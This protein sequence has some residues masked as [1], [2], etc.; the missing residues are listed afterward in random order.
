MVGGAAM[1]VRRTIV[2]ASDDGMGE[3]ADALEALEVAKRGYEAALEAHSIPK[4]Y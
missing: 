1:G 3:V 2:G 4:P